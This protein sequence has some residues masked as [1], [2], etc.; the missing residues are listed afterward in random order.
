MPNVGPNVPDPELKHCSSKSLAQIMLSHEKTLLY[1]NEEE[2]SDG[3]KELDAEEVKRRFDYISA[4]LHG[5]K[6]VRVPVEL[7]ALA[8]A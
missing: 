5:A 2:V 1:N 3:E 4:K 7:F 6:A 8:N